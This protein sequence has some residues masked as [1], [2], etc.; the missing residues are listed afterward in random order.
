M[1][2]YARKKKANVVSAVFQGAIHSNDETY[3]T[4]RRRKLRLTGAI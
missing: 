3:L 4:L 2:S 1:T